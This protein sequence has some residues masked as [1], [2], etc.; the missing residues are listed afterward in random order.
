MMTIGPVGNQALTAMVEQAASTLGAPAWIINARGAILA[1]SARDYPDSAESQNTDAQGSLR[2]KALL[3]GYDDSWMVMDLG[4]VLHPSDDGALRL[5]QAYLDLLA[6]QIVVHSI[7][8]RQRLKA[9]LIQ[10]LLF[11]SNVDE[12]QAQRQGEML[13]VDLRLP[14]AIILVDASACLPPTVEGTPPEEQEAQSQRAVQHVI[15]SIVSY[16]HLP[17]DTIRAYLG[18]GEVAV[19]KAATAQD[20]SIWADA[21]DQ[22]PERGGA[23]WASLAALQRACKGLL[24]RLRRDTGAEI[25][26]GIGRYHPGV[27]GLARSYADAR[28]ALTIGRRLYGANR[29]HCLDQL[30]VAAFVAGADERTKFEL[31]RR[32]LSPL[33]QEPDLLLTLQMFFE[34]DCCPSATAT[35]LCVHRNTV[36]F[37]LEKI[38]L[39]TGLDPRH[40]DDAV[41]IRLALLLNDLH[42]Q[43]T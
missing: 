8:D 20:L 15:Q 13:G 5:A 7:P 27:A 26:I 14:R 3:G 16:F 31:A 36:R 41:Q 38:A 23:S 28:A 18:V 34:K 12:E 2:I 25:T 1:S 40:F 32:L 42:E 29:L 6:R 17:T 43:E 4:H 39:L 10:N 30:G 35:A 19:L 37:R 11:S 21:E 33:A 9:E 22:Q 24:T